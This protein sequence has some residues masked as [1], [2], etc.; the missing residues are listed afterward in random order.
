MFVGLVRALPRECLHLVGKTL[1]L[2]DKA[3]KLN[4]RFRSD[5]SQK[6]KAKSLLSIR[7]CPDVDEDRSHSS[8]LKTSSASIEVAPSSI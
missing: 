5:V 6:I 1:R 7:I 4:D 8:L 2:V 3:L